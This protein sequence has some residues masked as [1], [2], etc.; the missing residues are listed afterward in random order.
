MG[1]ELTMLSPEQRHLL[2]S[3]VPVALVVA[4]HSWGLVGTT[5]LELSSEQGSL[6]LK[7][8]GPS[9]HH[10]ARELRAHR[11]WL[12]PWVETGH[13]PTL[14]YGDVSRRILITR[15]LPG[16]LVEG[17]PAQDDPETYRQAGSLLARYHGQLS[18]YDPEWHDRFRTRVQRHLDLPHR[19][20]PSILRMVRAEVATWPDGGSD[21][22]PTHGD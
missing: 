10:I 2:A 15:Y 22:V 12:R 17:T 13:A 4:D 7:A 6:V 1:D 3:W 18:T 21:V 8:G 16:R 5:V 11:E 19:I 20:E 9:D 14:V